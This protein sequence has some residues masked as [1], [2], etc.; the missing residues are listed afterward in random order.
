[1]LLTLYIVVAAV[2]KMNRTREAS[3]KAL[4]WGTLR[5]GGIS[6]C[7]NMQGR[8]ASHITGFSRVRLPAL[9]KQVQ[10]GQSGQKQTY[11]TSLEDLKPLKALV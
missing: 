4:S 1:M 9:P 11:R 3:Q 5:K 6:A 7:K 10:H 2:L 8:E